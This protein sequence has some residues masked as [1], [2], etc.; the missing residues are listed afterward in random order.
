MRAGARAP[1]TSSAGAAAALTKHQFKPLPEAL[2]FRFADERT[3]MPGDG[4]DCTGRPFSSLINRHKPTPRGIAKEAFILEDFII[5]FAQKKMS[6]VD[7]HLSKK[8]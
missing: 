3:A 4:D 8:R 5:F 2:P 7:G 6:P 1:P